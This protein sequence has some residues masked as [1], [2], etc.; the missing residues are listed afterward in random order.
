MLKE[1]YTRQTLILYCVYGTRA[2]YKCHKVGKYY[3]LCVIFSS[4]FGG[5]KVLWLH[6]DCLDEAEFKGG[7]SLAVPIG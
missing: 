6:L 4:A 5:R 3:A 7:L 2:L 1:G